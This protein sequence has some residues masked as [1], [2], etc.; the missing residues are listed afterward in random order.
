MKFNITR[1]KDTHAVIEMSADPKELQAIKEKV[2]KKLAPT[3]K[4]AG[5]RDGNVPPEVVEKNIPADQ[6]QSEFINEAVNTLY[7]E[8]LRQERIRPVSSPQVNVKAFVPY[9]QLDVEL[10][11]DVV[12]EI[13]LGDYKKLKAKPAKVEVEKSEIDEVIENLKIRLAE[14]KDVERAAKDGDEAWIDFKGVDAKGEPVKGA[15]GKDYP[16]VLGSNTFIPGFEENVVGMKAGDEKEFEVTFPKDYGMKSLQNAKVKFTVTLKKVQEVIKPEVN[17]DFAAK[18]GPFKTVD[19]LK[20]DITNQLTTEKE[21]RAERDYE[22]QLIDEMI[23]SSKVTV[24]DALLDEQK[25]AVLQEVRQSAVQRGM[26]FEDYLKQRDMTEEEFIKKEIVP[27]SEKRIKAGL[28]LSE[29]ADEENI[30]V[31]DSE[32]QARIDVLKSQYP[33]EQMKAQLESPEAKREIASR[34]RTEKVIQFL[35]TQK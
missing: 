24:P 23:A 29:I 17:A 16:L 1:D 32:V 13:K 19:E 5:F 22:N 30:G 20:A 8:V 3:V 7:I 6:L 12:G 35:K 26:T 18:V 28:I 15:D 25:Q 11:L 2:V 9:T 21:A 14:K 33:D 4:V 10:S 34:L 27:E 31:S